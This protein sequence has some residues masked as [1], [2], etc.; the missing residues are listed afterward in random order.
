MN[1]PAAKAGSI[2]NLFR[3]KGT[4]APKEPEKSITV[5]RL[6]PTPKPKCV[7]DNQ[8]ATTSPSRIP[9]RI[10]LIK[11]TRNSVKSRLP[12]RMMLISPVA[13]PLITTVAA[14]VPVFPPIAIITGM[15]KERAST[16]SMEP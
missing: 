1:G 12:V 13:R 16:F 10:P 3:T 8:K 5:I 6:I 11:A 15:K 4:K 9:H 14:W 7:S 2:S